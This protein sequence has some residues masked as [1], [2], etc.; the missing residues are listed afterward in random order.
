M[1]HE[2]ALLTI[3]PQPGMRRP[4]CIMHI[5]CILMVNA[6][7]SAKCLASLCCSVSFCH[8]LQLVP[9]FRCS[10]YCCTYCNSHWCTKFQVPVAALLFVHQATQRQ[11]LCTSAYSETLSSHEINNNCNNSNHCAHN[12]N[13][14][15][16]A[17]DFD[18]GQTMAMAKAKAQAMDKATALT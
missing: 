1:R 3:T 14:N 15:D 4:A 7:V 11:Q 18:V 9:C 12:Y 6:D 17:D 16:S 13:L 5:S 8:I 2:R 10:S